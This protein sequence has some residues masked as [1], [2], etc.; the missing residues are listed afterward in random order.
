M[1]QQGTAITHCSPVPQRTRFVVDG[2]E[3]L[4]H[5]EAIDFVFKSLTAQEDAPELTENVQGFLEGDWMGEI[6][7]N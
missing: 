1:V 3:G 6:N 4:L 2:G 5:S 7:I